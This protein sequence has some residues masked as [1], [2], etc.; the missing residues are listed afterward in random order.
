MQDIVASGVI[1]GA[2]YICAWVVGQKVA[3]GVAKDKT[4]RN[5]IRDYGRV[6]ATTFGTLVDTANRRLLK[7]RDVL[8]VR[9]GNQSTDGLLERVFLGQNRE[10]CPGHKI[11]HHKNSAAG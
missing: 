2:P 7:L 1:S 3:T 6:R 5:E 4:L 8:A 11:R 9:Y 10:A